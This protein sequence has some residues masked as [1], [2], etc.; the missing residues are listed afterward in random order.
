MA[1]GLDV[2]NSDD[3]LIVRHENKQLGVIREDSLSLDSEALNALGAVLP[4]ISSEQGRAFDKALS[5]LERDQIAI[6]EAGHAV[7]AYELGLRVCYARLDEVSEVQ[8]CSECDVD[9]LDYA[10]ELKVIALQ[11]YYAAGA[12][13]ERI[14][15]GTNRPHGI[16]KD[17]RDVN[18]METLLIEYQTG[19]LTEEVDVFEERVS[20]VQSLLRKQQ[21]AAIAN[22]LNRTGFLTREELESTLQVR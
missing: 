16:A 1:L 18:V 8:L 17:R 21:I 9:S 2:Q 19:T 15:Y 14:I 6:H 22:E 10:D 5:E 11:K 12:A 4:P 7:A 3:A 20:Q 13:A